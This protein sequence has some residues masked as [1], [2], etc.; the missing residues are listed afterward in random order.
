MNLLQ[1]MLLLGIVGHAVNCYCDRQLSIFPNGTLTFANLPRIKED[2]YAAK[3][4]AGVS[5]RVPMRAGVLG[6]FSCVLECFGY[7][8]LAFYAYQRAPI[9]GGLLFVCTVFFAA[10]AAAYHLKTALAEWAFLQYGMDARAKGLML[11]LL[12]CGAPLKACFAGAMG[13]YVTL[14]VAILTGAIGFPLWAVIFTI[15][16]IF[17]VLA[18]LKIVGTIHIASIVS[19]AAWLFLL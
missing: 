17:L 5:P 6:V 3:L 9:Y 7:A 1:G 4:M 10:L 15:L 8:A 19:M 13:Y 12:Q 14:I 11:D 16:P 18:P 2:G